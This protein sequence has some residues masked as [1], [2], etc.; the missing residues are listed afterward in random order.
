MNLVIVDNHPLVRKGLASILVQEKEFEKIH[1]ASGVEEGMNLII[2][3]KPDIAMIDISLGKEDGLQ[4]V[5]R[6]KTMVFDT[7]F[8]ILTSAIK[9]EEFWRAEKIGV[10]GYILKKAFAEDLLYAIRL[11]KRGKK[12]YD[13]DILE[14]KLMQK[15]NN[16]IYQ[17]TPR[18]KDVFNQL[19]K[20]LSNME[21]AK[22]LYISE[23]TVKKHVSN[24]LSKLNLAHRT[25]AVIFALNINKCG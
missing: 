16:A 21:I 11:I 14:Y 5:E 24:I 18:E 7:K 22:Q 12:Y 6:G 25:Q 23:H 15:K 9:Q 10:D 2:R 13:P 20:G 4:I 17:L 1:E 19:S 3:Q 8:I